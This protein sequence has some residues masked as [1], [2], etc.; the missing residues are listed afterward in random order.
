M[1]YC[2]TT[3]IEIVQGEIARTPIAFE[4]TEANVATFATWSTWDEWRINN[5]NEDESF[6]EHSLNPVCYEGC[7][8]VDSIDYMELS[9]IE[10]I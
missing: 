2:V 8:S 1:S 3:K 7:F 6:P 10:T 4:E 5:I 9:L